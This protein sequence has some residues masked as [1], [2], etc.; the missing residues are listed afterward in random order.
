MWDLTVQCTAN[1]KRRGFPGQRV[2]LAL[3]RRCLS[4]PTVCLGTGHSREGHLWI[5]PIR[6]LLMYD[7]RQI[8]QDTE[9]AHGGRPARRLRVYVTF[10]GWRKA[11]QYCT[12]AKKATPS[13]K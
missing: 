13:G 9:R 5:H 11:L 8:E 6:S 7:C 10:G 4:R 3:P 2:T 12:S 1:Y